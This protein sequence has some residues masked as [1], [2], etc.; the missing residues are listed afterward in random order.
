MFNLSATRLAWWL[1]AVVI[2]LAVATGSIALAWIVGIVAA[3]VFLL[4]PLSSGGPRVQ[5]SPEAWVKL[6][7]VFLVAIIVAWWIVYIPWGEF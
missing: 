3:G 5:V 4:W 7:L 1:T 2:V 6:L